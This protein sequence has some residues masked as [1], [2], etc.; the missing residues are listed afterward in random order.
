MCPAQPCA[1]LTE[2]RSNTAPFAYASYSVDQLLDILRSTVLAAEVAWNQV[3]NIA[4]AGAPDRLVLGYT[5][6]PSVQA[7]AYGWRNTWSGVYGIYGCQSCLWGQ[8]G[9]KFGATGLLQRIGPDG[10]VQQ[11]SWSCLPAAASVAAPNRTRGV[12]GQYL[13]AAAPDEC[14]RACSAVPQ[15]AG[16]NY[17]EAG[18]VCTFVAVVALGSATATSLPTGSANFAAL[19]TGSIPASCYSRAMP[20]PTVVPAAAWTVCSGRCSVPP[21]YAVPAPTTADLDLLASLAANMTLGARLE[22]ELEDKLLAANGHPR[23]QGIMMDSLERW[24]RVAGPNGTVCLPPLYYRPGTWTFAG[25]YTKAADMA[26]FG[27]RRTPTQQAAP[28]LLALQSWAAGEPQILPFTAEAAP[29]AGDAA[30]AAAACVWGTCLDGACVCFAGYEGAD[31]AAASAARPANE[32]L[33][34]GVPVGMNLAG[35]SYWSTEAT[36]VDVFKT[37]GLGDTSGNQGWV[38][39][40][41][42]PHKACPSGFRQGRIPSSAHA[43][44]ASLPLDPRLTG[45]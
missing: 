27:L 23:M 41:P 21:F 16:F 38:A 40:V 28:K 37:S 15:C 10:W 11:E 9:V 32:C 20:A 22:Q 5:S 26:D 19:G 7:A 36:Y 4:R 33:D 24:R 39:Q 45:D 25:G 29:A 14:K 6:G 1:G 17:D 43:A 35:L 42:H 13:S 31:C 3:A 8:M 34:P 2:V 18:R 12:P 30:C 44:Q